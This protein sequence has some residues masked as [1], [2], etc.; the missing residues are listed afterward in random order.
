M[1]VNIHDAKTNLSKLIARAKKGEEVIIA[2]AG[3]PQVVLT[4]IEAK[5]TRVPGRFKGTFTVGDAFFEPLPDSELDA[6]EGR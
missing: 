4:V 1:T 2:K 5:K 3:E 6:W